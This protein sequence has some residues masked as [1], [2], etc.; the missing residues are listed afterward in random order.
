MNDVRRRCSIDHRDAPRGVRGLMQEAIAN[1]RI[2][3]IAATF[4]AVQS[5]A[6]TRTRRF[7]REIEKQREIGQNA[8]SRELADGPEV[9]GI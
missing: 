9:V 5:A 8:T 4:H 1:L 2:V 3:G 6:P 7:E